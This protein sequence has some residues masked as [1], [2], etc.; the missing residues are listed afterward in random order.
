MFTSAARG[1]NSV[2]QEAEKLCLLY[3]HTL[4]R[5]VYP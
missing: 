3:Y 4:P 5:L 1:A 2:I